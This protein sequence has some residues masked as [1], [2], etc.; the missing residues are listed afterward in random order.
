MDNRD[1][2]QTNAPR[3]VL[4]DG[5]LKASL[6]RNEGEKGP[7]YSASLARTWRDEEGRLHD[8]GSFSGA[9]LLRVSELARKAYDR[10]GE[11]RREEGKAP[12]RAQDQ[13]TRRAA[14]DSRRS[15]RTARREPER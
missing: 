10:M 15:Q 7:F 1:N 5:N 13:G 2:E 12:E 3:D 6:W 14:F 11:L 4:R 8:S 9:E